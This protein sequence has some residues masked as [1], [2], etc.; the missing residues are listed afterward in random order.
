[1]LASLG[2]IIIATIAIVPAALLISKG[3]MGAGMLFA[4]VV[5]AT[6]GLTWAAL[7]LRLGDYMRDAWSVAHWAVWIVVTVLA[8]TP[9]QMSVKGAMR[10]G[11]PMTLRL[12]GALSMAGLVAIVGY[13]LMIFWPDFRAMW[14][15]TGLEPR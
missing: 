12:G 2:A 11:D 10:D 7:A 13:C 6:A 4:L 15:W 9:I 14:S 8:L 5:G 3:R 1:M